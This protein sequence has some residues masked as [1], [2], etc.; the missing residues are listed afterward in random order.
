MALALI[1]L[2]EEGLRVAERLKPSLGEDADLFLPEKLCQQRPH[3]R[4]FSQGIRPLVEE[5]FGKYDGL[6]FIMAL[7]IVV[8]AVAP[9]IKDKLSDPAVVVVDD[10]GR[11]AVSVLSGHEGGANDLALKAANILHGEAVITTGTEAK[12]DII[13]GLGCK[14]DISSG[15]VKEAILTSLRAC[16]IPLE[17][18]RLAATIEER[19]R[20]TGLCDGV[21]ELGIP[22]KVISKEEISTCGKEFSRSEF[23]KEKVGVWG[24]CEPT[25]LLAGRKTRLILKKQK[26][27][28]VTVA[29]AQENLTW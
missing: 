17:R 14:A 27:P 26:Y 13:I 12:K 8:R 10:V 5:I 23:V 3:A 2:T 6:I 1:T 7:G 18:V 20:V 19:A 9:H 25:A 16:N 28:G 22:L 21:R 11:F 4:P 29:I 15:M 24:V